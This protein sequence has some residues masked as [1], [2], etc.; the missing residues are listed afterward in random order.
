MASDFHTT[1]HTYP[2]NTHNKTL[3]LTTSIME[4]FSKVT[5]NAPPTTSPATSSAQPCTRAGLTNYPESVRGCIN[6]AIPLNW[7]IQAQP[8]ACI[9]STPPPS[10]GKFFNPSSF[11]NVLINAVHSN[12]TL[13]SPDPSSPTF[14]IAQ[15][16]SSTTIS[17]TKT[18]ESEEVST[19]EPTY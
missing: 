7:R 1:T 3:H 9:V 19:E 14:S 8:A 18:T 4:A 16:T 13:S 5:M 2:N 6:P 11:R 15:S 12:P 17:T 10:E